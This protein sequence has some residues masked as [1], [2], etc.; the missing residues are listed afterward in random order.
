MYHAL[1]EVIKRR[2]VGDKQETKPCNPKE[3]QS[4]KSARGEQEPKAHFTQAG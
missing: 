2:G 1:I 4:T 3:P